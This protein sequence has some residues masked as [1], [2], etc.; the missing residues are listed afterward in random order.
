MAGQYN[1]P[2]YTTSNISI[3]PGRVYIG[4]TGATPTTD[5]GAVKVGMKIALKSTIVDVEQGNPSM[6]VA[7]F[8]Q[9]DE[10]DVTFTGLEWNLTNLAYA[11][12]G[13]G[14]GSGA[15]LL[16]F[17]GRIDL[18]KVAIK[19]THRTPA[20]NTITAMVWQARGDGN[21]EMNLTDS[22]HEHNHTFKAVVGL[23]DWGGTALDPECQLVRI[24]KI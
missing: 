18:T 17:G 8:H 2:T 6:V 13:A 11:L 12:G 9:K 15:N 5:V 14:T 7:S 10:V 3:G 1:L 4:A 21:M 19:F 23:T 16:T 20:G 24:T 22:V